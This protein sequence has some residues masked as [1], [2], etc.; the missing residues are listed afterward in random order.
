MDLHTPEQRRIMRWLEQQDAA[1][2][3]A[4][5]EAVTKNALRI[6]ER[7]GDSALVICRQDGS[8]KVMPC[9]EAC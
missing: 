1:D 7:T 4:R 6:Y 8:M 9:D 5:V 2:K 3:L